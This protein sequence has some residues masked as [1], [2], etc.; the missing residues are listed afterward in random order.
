MFGEEIEGELFWSVSAKQLGKGLQEQM[1]E[2][3]N[4]HK[5]ASLIVIDTLQKVREVGGDTYSYASDYELMNQFKTFGEQHGVSILMVHHTR[6]Q[7]AGDSFDMI[8]GTTGLL[9][10][11]DGAFVMKKEKR[12]DN[13]AT[14]ELVGRDQPDQKLY[15]L[16]NEENLQWELE[17][18]ER[19]LWKRP[20]DA[21]LEQVA[22]LVTEEQPEWRGSA[23]E[24]AELVGDH[25]NGI[26]KKLNRRARWLYEDYGIVYQRNRGRTGSQITL[27]RETNRE[28]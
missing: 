23:S 7:Q 3:V 6:K 4:Q 17:G 15:L 22:Q 25:A 11:A 12:T 18:V 13:R 2:F 5:N 28:I 21:L 14:L 20:P 8:S 27:T 24:L 1:K 19:E 9:G 26:V 10:C 16:R